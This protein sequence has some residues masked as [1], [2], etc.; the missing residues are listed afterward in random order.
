MKKILNY[1][2]EHKTFSRE[3]ARE[4]LTSISKGVYNESELAAF[5]KQMLVESLE[6]SQAERTAAVA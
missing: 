5:M 3:G 4:I 2:F 1:L 6:T